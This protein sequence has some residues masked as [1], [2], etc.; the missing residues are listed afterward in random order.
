M[1]IGLADR[2]HVTHVFNIGGK[3][4]VEG[5]W[6]AHI[7]PVAVCTNRS[8]VVKPHPMVASHTAF[9]AKSHEPRTCPFRTASP[10]IAF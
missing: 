8:I 4:G 3:H 9:A 10:T 1:R 5:A 6:H 7:N 2:H